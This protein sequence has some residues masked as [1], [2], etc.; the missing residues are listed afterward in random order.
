LGTTGPIVGCVILVMHSSML[1]KGPAERLPVVVDTV[2][3]R[4]DAMHADQSSPIWWGMVI[5][6]NFLGMEVD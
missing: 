5:V 4:L 2:P 3:A 1:G 6:P